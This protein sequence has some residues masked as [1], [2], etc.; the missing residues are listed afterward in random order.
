M[1]RVLTLPGCESCKLTVGISRVNVVLPRS[2]VI[3]I[4]TLTRRRVRTLLYEYHRRQNPSSLFRLRNEQR[5]ATEARTG[6]TYLDGAGE[7]E[8][9]RLFRS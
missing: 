5:L 8:K 2:G 1:P 6:I 4:V 3:S 9:V 7:V